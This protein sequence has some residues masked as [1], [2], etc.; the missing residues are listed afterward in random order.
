MQDSD[1]SGPLKELR[2]GTK[3]WYVLK[4]KKLYVFKDIQGPCSQVIDVG[5]C[6]VLSQKTDIRLSMPDFPPLILEAES[7]ELHEQWTI[8]LEKCKYEDLDEI[9]PEKYKI[10]KPNTDEVFQD[11]DYELP[12][13]V[14][15]Q[16]ERI[17]QVIQSL[18]ILIC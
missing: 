5:S 3:Y 8:A 16:V 10:N 2:E 12:V 17:R 9:M 13:H 7:E 15:E 14:I 4:N 11:P 1:C 18:A 6:E